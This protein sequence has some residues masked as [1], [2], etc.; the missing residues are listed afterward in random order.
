MSLEVRGLRFFLLYVAPMLIVTPIW[1]HLRLAERRLSLSRR[2]LLDA[3]VVFMA[4]LRGIGVPGL[5]FSGHTLF[6]AYSGIV[7]RHRGYRVLALLLMLETTVFKLWLWRDPKSWGLGIAIGVLLA[8]AESRMTSR[9][10][11]A[12]AGPNDI[13]RP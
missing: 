9:R 12:K 10:A 7:T 6:L 8:V 1:L 13:L 2:W 3:V 11:L 4:A 5:P